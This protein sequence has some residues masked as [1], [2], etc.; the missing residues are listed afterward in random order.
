[1]LLWY[2]LDLVPGGQERWRCISP[3]RPGETCRRRGRWR[4]GE[5]WTPWCAEVAAG[6][7]GDISAV[8]DS[9]LGKRPEPPRTDWVAACGC[10]KQKNVQSL[11]D[12][13]REVRTPHLLSSLASAWC[14][15]RTPRWP[16]WG[17]PVSSWPSSR[18]PPRRDT[19]HCEH[20]GPAWRHCSQPSNC[21]PADL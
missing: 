20:C 12:W 21:R 19:S 10:L 8:T 7:P 13:M 6:S 18:T 11:F 1:M 2:V 16:W 15:W 17:G 14:E 4:G 5:V 9:D 3:G